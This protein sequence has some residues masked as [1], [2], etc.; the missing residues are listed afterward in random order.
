MSAAILLID[1]EPGILRLL[2]RSFRLWQ[3][4]VHT[5]A[6][7]RDALDIVE[8]ERPDVVI[9]DL[10]MPGLS[11]LELL[12]VL[13]AADPDAAVIPLTGRGDV[14][15][16][17]Q[18]MHLGAEFF[19]TKPVEL[20]QL[21]AVADRA[22]E[23]V[24]LR[25]QN[26]FLAAGQNDAGPGLAGFGATPPMRALAAQIELIGSSDS[27]VLLQGE[28][29][30]GK[31]H[32]A[33]RI[34]ARSARAA[35]PFVHVNCGGLSATFLDS[36][37]FGHERGAFTDAKTQKRG[38]FEVANGGTLFL[39]EIGDL[40]TELQPKLLTVLE[41][42]RFRRLGGTHE[43]EVDVRVIAATNRPLS[44]EVRSG[45]FREDLYYRLA[46]FPIELPPLR[47]RGTADV[48]E[49]VYASLRDL[50]RSLGRGPTRV[51]T[52]A[53]AHLTRYAW[54]GNIRELRNVLE[55]VLLVAGEAE[56]VLPMHLPAELLDR[57]GRPDDAA[58][59]QLTLDEVEMRHIRRVLEA[60]GGNRTRA[61][62]VLGVS[63]KTL[64]SKLQRVPSR[65]AK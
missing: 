25:R 24:E 52:E 28:T 19:L 37:L 13:R 61:A 34:H 48:V 64:Y 35:R 31:G 4:Q 44:E 20:E 39:D 29:G 56:T 5:A 46:V 18:A 23:K 49:L 33:R 50:R 27:T 36:E 57:A 11:G 65:P 2:E 51:S 38:L 60:C 40:A 21:R 8:R 32:V 12:R 63:R 58:E 10:N 7:G 17:V 54:P 43:I 30:T 45:R 47:Q 53:L 41:S 62:E 14:Q 3:W 16:A 15:T 1:D 59:T 42:R 26:R 9:Q 55:R 22:W 6:S